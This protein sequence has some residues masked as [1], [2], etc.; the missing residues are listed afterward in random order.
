MYDNRQLVQLTGQSGA[1]SYQVEDSLGNFLFSLP[2]RD[3]VLDYRF[4]SGRLQ[5]HDKASGRDGFVDSA[6]F[7]TL[8]G[9]SNTDIVE[10]VTL[11]ADTPRITS[12]S[13]SHSGYAGQTRFGDVELKAIGSNH[14]FAKEA[15]KV[16]AGKLSEDDSLSRRKILSYCEHLRSAYTT[17]DLD[18]IRQVFSDHALIIVGHTVKTD[19]SANNGMMSKERV[20]YCVRSK[21]QY[22]Q[23]LQSVFESN[24]AINVDFSDFRIMRHPTMEGIY[25][26]SLH[27]KYRSDRY[28][29]NGYLFLL[30]DFRDKGLPLIHVRTWQPNE[31]IA[32][33]EDIID[34]GDF[35]LQ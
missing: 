2:L 18:F 15:K 22:L 27:Q 32:L 19:S 13:P 7:V 24:K 28:S 34:I 26:V 10:T 12:P 3:C 17:K 23:K 29:D 25:G 16:L 6:G 31:N 8:A 4:R 20:A 5:F 21:Q 1:T 11:T 33:G 9:G 35:N 30:W 14:P